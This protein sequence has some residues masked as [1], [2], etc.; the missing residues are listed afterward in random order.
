MNT[1][2]ELLENVDNMPIDMQEKFVEIAVEKLNYR[3]KKLF[4]EET[5]VS[6]KEYISGE[7]IEGSPEKLFQE[8][9]I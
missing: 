3:K 7:F 6:Q 5:L 2:A 4:L 9:E 1:F 8:L